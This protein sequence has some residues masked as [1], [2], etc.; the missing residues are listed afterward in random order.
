MS[1]AE[2][3]TLTRDYAESRAYLTGIIT[4]L[5]EEL[6]R[7]KHPVLPVIREGVGQSAEAHAKL[8]A[9]LESSPELFIKPRTL[10]IAGIRIGYMK[11]R[12][13]VVIADDEAVI[14]RMRALLPKN[15]ADLM[16]TVKES[17]HKPSVS[18]LTAAD[19]KRLGISITADEDIVT[20]KPVDDE[21]DK[22][23]N[24]LL[25]EAEKDTR[26][27]DSAA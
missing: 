2:I 16:I 22:L 3:E 7:I 8:K 18:D 10:T 20:I 5:H 12:G 15:Q 14:K 25:A 24:A 13:K 23:V 6:E 19:L 21:V 26:Q 17:V 11:Q 4:A 1:L 27:T 9:A